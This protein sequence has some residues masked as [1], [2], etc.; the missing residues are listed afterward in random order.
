MKKNKLLI[1][2]GNRK[3]GPDYKPLII[4][5]LGINHNGN[6]KRAKKLVDHAHKFG[7][8]IIKH[9]TH[10]VEDEMSE[11]AKKII[12]SH[13]KKNI[14]DIIKSSAL[15]ESDEYKLMKYVNKKKMIFI[16][17]PFSRKAVDRLIKFKVPGFKIGSGECNNYPLIEYIAKYKKPIILS[18]GMNS[19]SSIKPAVK[20]LE[21]YKVPYALLHCT[22]IYPTPTNLVRLQAISKLKEAFP[23]AILGL[24][25]HSKTIYP[26]IGAIAL[27]ASIIE[28]HFVDNKNR[29]GPDIS[30]SMDGTE[31]KNL[32]L[33]VNE[34]HLAKGNY[35]GPVK[36]E[37]STINFAFASLVTTKNINKGEKLTIK[38]IFPKRPGIGDFKAKDY[39]KIIGKKAKRFIKANTLLKKRDI[40]FY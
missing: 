39:N 20:I 40:N 26:C 23:K 4:V 33:A 7:A 9:Q 31:L 28:K 19:I 35:K 2:I 12:P 15:S 11:E 29:V 36:E 18:T 21:K 34:V 10:V 17:T 37:K 3:I 38:N 5:E 14:F 24:S 8:E 6:L 13:T 1:K 22:N 30:A 32:M 16:S 27:G 25:D